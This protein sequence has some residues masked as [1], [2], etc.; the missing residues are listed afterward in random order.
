[1]H[2]QKR[3][4]RYIYLYIC[5]FF[6]LLQR[7]ATGE[8]RT[9]SEEASLYGLCCKVW[10]SNNARQQKMCSV[11]YFALTWLKDNGPVDRPFQHQMCMHITGQGCAIHHIQRAVRGGSRSRGLSPHNA[12]ATARLN[13]CVPPWAR[14]TVC[15][16]FFFRHFCL[17]VP[18]YLKLN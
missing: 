18:Y 8:E 12:F 11:L 7:I 9:F 1:M 6:F 16:F 10:H 14:Y 5:V 3:I 2:R 15:V 13:L 4:K 17:K